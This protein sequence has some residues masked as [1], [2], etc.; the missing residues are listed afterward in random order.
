MRRRFLVFLRVFASLWLI[1]LQAAWAQEPQVTATVDSAT[2]AIDENLQLT[3]KISGGSIGDDQYPRVQRLRGFRVMGSP[4]INTQFQWM[5]GRSSSSKSFIY[6]LIPEREGPAAID[7]IEVPVGHKTYR[8]QPISIR[9]TAASARAAPPR[10]R[11]LDPFGNDDFRSAPHAARL[12]EEVFVTA[13]LDR[14]SAYPGQQVTLSY[15]LYTMVGVGGIQLQENP[16]LTGFWVEDLAVDPSP[17]GSRKAINGKEYVDYVVKK[18]ALF[19]NTVGVLKISPSTFAVSVKRGDFFGLFGQAE[20]LYRK[21]SEVSLEVKPFPAR[22]RPADFANGVGSFTLTSSLDKTEAAVGDAVALR[23]KLSGRGNLKM[24]PDLPLPQMPDFTIYSS[25][26]SDNVRA[27]EENL[28]G[29]DKSWEY[30]I[31]PKAPGPQTVPPFTFSYF[32]PKREAYE[33]VTT[34][35]LDLKVI[36][37]SDDGSSITGLSG[38]SKQDLTRQGTDI[39]FI[40][41]SANDL[42]TGPAPIYRSLW[43]YLAAAIPL[44]FNIGALLYSRERARESENLPLARS[45]KARRNSLARLKR[46]EKIAAQEPRRFYD[47]AAAALSGYLTD[48]FNL[49]EIAVTGDSLERS[50]KEGRVS[51]ETVR[52]TMVCLQECDFGRFVSASSSAQNMRELAGRIR[53]IIYSLEQA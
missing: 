15:H 5:N 53:K 20:T 25:K 46:A 21:T 7:P 39:N 6:T 48:K 10:R 52:E 42:E 35:P 32:D 14:S 30:V 22:G 2:V 51:P 47:E 50:L 29:G 11:S 23:V 4:S 38:I 36:R 40:K 24:I 17:D 33:T 27:V 41:L 49:P 16:P 45:R 12:G 8:T 3:I 26:L 9:V 19:P 44:L 13:E 18:H 43:F 34:P 31:V 28:I 1:L 37:R